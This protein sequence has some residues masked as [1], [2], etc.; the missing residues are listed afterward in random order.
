M[1]SYP[2]YSTN[3]GAHTVS[4]NG[5]EVSMFQCFLNVQV[6]Q[7]YN[8]WCVGASLSRVIPK[9]VERNEPLCASGHVFRQ[10]YRT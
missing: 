4:D 5:D 2:L 6:L 8:C 1:H 7:I 3:I 9:C 10:A